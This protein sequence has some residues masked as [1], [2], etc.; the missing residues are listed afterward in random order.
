VLALVLLLPLALQI[1][2]AGA[3]PRAGDV[4]TR[5]APL[6]GPGAEA[7]ASDRARLVEDTDGTLSVSLARPDGATAFSRRFPRAASCEEQAERVAVTVAVWEA[8]IHPEISLRLE[9]LGAPPA[10]TPVPPAAPAPAADATLRR[11]PA[12]APAPS[13]VLSIGAAAVGAFNPDA[14]PGGRLDL[15]WGRG[16]HW[17]WRLSSAWLGKHTVDLSPGQASW[18]RL[19][20]ALGADYVLPFGGRWDVT[21]GAAGVAGFATVEGDGFTVDR[22]TRTGD[23]GAEGMLQV[24]VR[25]GRVRPWLGAGM[26]AWLRPQRLA[27]TGVPASVTM[28][29]FEPVVAA[30]AEFSWQP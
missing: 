20:A 7:A 6:L 9:R 14:V 26:L 15:T 27:A 8:Q 25:L 21:L 24:G 28:P 17:R 10:P 12:T 16:R 13:G 1:D 18:W 5:L 22:T 2:A 3:C 19:Y 23:L 29:R 11:Q 30:G 4:E